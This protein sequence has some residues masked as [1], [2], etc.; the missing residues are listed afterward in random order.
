MRFFYRKAIPKLG[1]FRVLAEQ[2]IWAN[3]GPHGEILKGLYKTIVPLPENHVI[4][5]A[6]NDARGRSTTLSCSLVVLVS[7]DLVRFTRS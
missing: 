3:K 7:C 4:L 2:S 6:A 5:R 1:F